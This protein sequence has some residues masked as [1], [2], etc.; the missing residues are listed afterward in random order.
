MAEAARLPE[1][2]RLAHSQFLHPNKIP[3]ERV[4]SEREQAFLAQHLCGRPDEVV[5]ALAYLYKEL[6]QL[7]EI[8]THVS[9]C[10]LRIIAEGVAAKVDAV[11]RGPDLVHALSCFAA[12]E[13]QHANTFY[14]YVRAATKFDHARLDNL[15]RERIAVYE[16]SESPLVKLAALVTTAYVGE[17]VITVF[18]T[19]MKALD[20][21]LTSSFTQLLH[22]HG[23]DEA[24]HVQSDHFV[25]DEIIP[26]FSKPE[27]RQ[28]NDLIAATERLNGQL[29]A[30][31]TALVKE[32]FGV[33][34]MEGNESAQMQLAITMA[35]RNAI[36]DS[37]SVRRVDAQIDDGTRA[38]LRAFSASER[39]HG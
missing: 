11:W 32:H 16:G 22:L 21:Q 14:R 10:L 24:R 37:G 18:E 15:F 29:A 12:E 20:P 9:A 3:W 30:N 27:Q 34:Y 25:I 28:M 17:S 39:V 2:N 35:F 23:L 19:R 1:I 4:D 13:I 26:R 36:L 33:D 6:T 38:M 7:A 8:E 31:C 5:K